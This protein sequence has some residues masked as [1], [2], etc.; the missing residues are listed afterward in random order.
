M[1]FTSAGRTS[2][3]CD[4]LAGGGPLGAAGEEAAA[5]EPA[6]AG[7][8]D[9]AVDGVVEQQ[10]LALALL[11]GQADAGGHR[12]ADVP[13]PQPLAGQPDGAGGRLPGAVDG[14]EDLRAAGADQPGEP[15]DLARARR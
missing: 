7:D 6:E 4:L 11:G 2:R 5:G 9:V 10:S 8:A 1:R 12:G 3:A 13:V 14:L 15:D